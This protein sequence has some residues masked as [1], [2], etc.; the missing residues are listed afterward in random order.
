MKK[1][2][3]AVLAVAAMALTAC[4]VDNVAAC[5]DAYAKI[6]ALECIGDA[7]LDAE[8]S[9]P[10]TLNEGGLDCSDFYTCFG[11]GYT[12]DGDTLQTDVADCPT[13]G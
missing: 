11:D 8:A 2:A 1:T 7:T 9:C 5:K 13:C 10:D 4:G 3:F 6:N 12:C